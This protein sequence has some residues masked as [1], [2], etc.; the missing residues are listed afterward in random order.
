MS[1]KITKDHL[2]TKSDPYPSGVGT[3]GPRGITDEEVAKLDKGEGHRFRMYDDDG[4][5]YYS[6]LYLGDKNSED[7]FEPLDCYGTPNAG[8]VRIDYIN[9][10]NGKW[11]EL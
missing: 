8:A 2:W 6:G 9:D 5:L 3:Y 11:E 1:F 10:V 7:A 4:E